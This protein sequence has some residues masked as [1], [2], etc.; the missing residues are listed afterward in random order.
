MH[1][2]FW[3]EFHASSN[4]LDEGFD[5]SLFTVFHRVM[6]KKF[7]REIQSLE[8]VFDFI[9][10]YF[11]ENPIQEPVLFSVKF[12]IEEVFTN[13]VKYNISDSNSDIAIFLNK[14]GNQ[15]TIR[16]TDFG[17]NQFDI[18]KAKEVDTTLPLEDRKVGGLGIHLIRKMVDSIDY[19]YSNRQSTI[20]LIKNLE[21]E[22]V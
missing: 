14:T 18:T 4:T 13:M 10:Q 19:E 6:Q 12:V 11:A 9:D 2:T 20:T 16:L 3:H 21:S 17:V 8:K 1:I 5:Q 15:L 7:R 22:Y